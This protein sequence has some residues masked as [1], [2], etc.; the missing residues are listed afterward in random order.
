MLAS[1]SATARN[2]CGQ[3]RTLARTLAHAPGHSVTAFERGRAKR[4]TTISRHEASQLPKGKFRRLSSSSGIDEYVL[5]SPAELSSLVRK[6]HH[7]QAYHLLRDL[8]ERR[9]PIEPEEVYLNAAKSILERPEPLDHVDEFRSWLSL[10]PSMSRSL[11]ADLMSLRAR[12]AEMQDSAAAESDRHVDTSLDSLSDVFLSICSEKGYSF[13]DQAKGATASTSKAR[14]PGRPSS[15]AS[16]PLRTRLSESEAAVFRAVLSELPD[17][18]PELAADES[19]DFLFEDDAK[20][21]DYAWAKTVS[22]SESHSRATHLSEQS[23]ALTAIDQLRVA[24]QKT[25]YATAGRLLHELSEVGTRIPPAELYLTPLLN[26]LKHPYE[27]DHPL[28]HHMPTV[29]DAFSAWFALI[30]DAEHIQDPG[31]L[32]LQELR[33]HIFHTNVVNKDLVLTFG[34]AAAKKGYGEQVSGQLIH[35][36]MGAFPDVQEALKY[37]DSF[38]EASEDHRRLQEPHQQVF[39]PTL[40]VRRKV[41]KVAFRALVR[42]GHFDI[43][44]DLLFQKRRKMQQFVPKESIR[45]AAGELQKARRFDLLAK[46]AP[47]L[48]Q[49]EG[50]PAAGVME[51][52]DVEA[53]YL[54]DIVDS[55][56]GRAAADEE[57]SRGTLV[58]QLRH[59]RRAFNRGASPPTCATLVAFMDQY[60]DSGRRRAL[61]LLRQRAVRHG[62]AGMTAYTFAQMV[63]LRRRKRDTL[64]IQVFANT[65]Y[66]AGVPREPILR[67]LQTAPAHPG[68]ASDVAAF[69]PDPRE[70][71][72][73]AWPDSMTTAVV[74]HSVT[75]LT[76]GWQAV[77]ALYRQ[78]LAFAAGDASADGVPALLHRPAIRTEAFMPFIRRLMLGSGLEWGPRVLQDMV[79]LGISPTIYHFT[80]MAGVYARKNRIDRVMM[81]VDMVEDAAASGAGKQDASTRTTDPAS[82]ASPASEPSNTMSMTSGGDPAL[83]NSDDAGPRPSEDV[84]EPLVAHH[85]AALAAQQPAHQP[86]KVGSLPGADLIFYVCVI[87]G[88]I[89]ARNLEGA[90]AIEE[91]MW[92]H[93]DYQLGNP[94]YESY[95]KD[96]RRMQEHSRRRQQ[97]IRQKWIARYGPEHAQEKAEET[98][99]ERAD[100]VRKLYGL[101]DVEALNSVHLGP[102]GPRVAEA[103]SEVTTSPEEIP[104]P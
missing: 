53:A 76:V 104:A 83:L 36:A 59:L 37:M 55:H 60:Y 28:R 10:V 47:L 80:D 46:I 18:L 75:A 61:R 3:V 52:T 86:R 11:A 74:W 58:V 66:L 14:G 93:Y 13:G 29:T 70:V 9:T 31:Y 26:L 97:N 7:E 91:R 84:A 39:R 101:T 42:D 78:L 38:V 5:G 22:S 63:F 12:I 56:D 32:T 16:K 72:Q 71:R 95:F 94:Y 8:Q 41:Y 98:L 20:D 23:T 21:D 103:E 2:P 82:Q 64:L 62:T 35:F 51:E 85:D 96:L 17:E 65:F 4:P 48:D 6:G 67:I 54:R 92:R 89:I 49:L 34:L 44:V 15:T 100:R 73:K 57:F 1:W 68:S 88:F 50:K 25:D 90:L 81:I 43:A 102:Y 99:K 87:R 19:D 27:R 77:Q 69:V 40:S 24:V 45:Y 33:R 79:R 30:P